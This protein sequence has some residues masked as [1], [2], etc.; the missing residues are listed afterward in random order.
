MRYGLL[1]K[2]L[3]KEVYW[4]RLLVIFA[5]N[6]LVALEITFVGEVVVRLTISIAYFVVDVWLV[7]WFW[8]LTTVRC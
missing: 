6:F 3:K 8:P 5:L 4:F 7:L 2:D 1:I